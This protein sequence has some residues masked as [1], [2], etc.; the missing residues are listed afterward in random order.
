MFFRGRQTTRFNEPTPKLLYN[1]NLCMRRHEKCVRR[2][3]SFRVT[4]LIVHC[5]GYAISRFSQLQAFK[6]RQLRKGGGN[7][8]SREQQF[9][10]KLIVWLCRKKLFAYEPSTFNIMSRNFTHYQQ[11]I[12]LFLFSWRNYLHMAQ[13]AFDKNIFS[14]IWKKF[15]VVYFAKQLKTNRLA[16]MRSCYTSL[17][18]RF[19]NSWHHEQLIWS[20]FS[21]HKLS[22]VHSR[23]FLS[24]HGERFLRW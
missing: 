6:F 23:D 22:Q 5:I 16:R 20:Q 8:E 4:K 18:T 17:E 9:N 10:W 3:T 21:Q 24:F 2:Q 7:C 19:D 13:F 12:T 11:V 15:C 1:I 14:L